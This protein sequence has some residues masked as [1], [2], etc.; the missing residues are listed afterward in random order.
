[1]A[2]NDRLC[3]AAWENRWWIALVVLCALADGWRLRIRNR[4]LGEALER[5]ERVSSSRETAQLERLLKMFFDARPPTLASLA[6][7]TETD[8]TL[9][10]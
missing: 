1:M 7:D 4:C 10:P 8:F 6:D 2:W 9:K 5:R 3:L